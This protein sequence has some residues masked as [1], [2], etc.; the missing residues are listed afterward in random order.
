MIEDT[1]VLNFWGLFD[2]L[3]VCDSTHVLGTVACNMYHSLWLNTS[4]G[5]AMH[6][7]H[8]G[9]TQGLQYYNN[10]L[11]SY[12]MLGQDDTIAGMDGVHRY[13]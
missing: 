9:Y 6:T 11:Y 2:T 13:V 5:R 8:L 4:D 1:L 10:K 12:C 3:Y 7:A